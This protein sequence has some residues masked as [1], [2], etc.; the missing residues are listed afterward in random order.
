MNRDISIYVGARKQSRRCPNKM[1]R[2]FAG[3]TLIEIYLEK[4]NSITEYPVFLPS[5]KGILSFKTSRNTTRISTSSNAHS[6]LSIPMTTPGLCLKV[7]SN[8]PRQR[9]AF[10][11]RATLFFE[12]RPSLKRFSVLL[13]R[14]SLH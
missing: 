1:L 2:P 5:E 10:S 13:S 8:S 6:S 4:L 9:S 14:I 12:W 11:I 3:T 7:S